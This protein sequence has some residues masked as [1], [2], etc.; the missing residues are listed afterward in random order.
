MAPSAYP[1]STGIGT[2]GGDIMMS[3]IALATDRKDIVAVPL[4]NPAPDSRLRLCCR[5]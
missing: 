1:A 5:V 4:E 2:D 3:C